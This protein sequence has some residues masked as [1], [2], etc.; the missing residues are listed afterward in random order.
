MLHFLAA[1]ELRGTP[2]KSP[3][4]KRGRGLSVPFAKPR[5]WAV[6]GGA[7]VGLSQT[8]RLEQGQPVL[9]GA[10]HLCLMAPQGREQ[11]AC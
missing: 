7:P 9:H 10:P 5:C 4:Q 8:P 2:A 1:E 11:A 6:G 3:S